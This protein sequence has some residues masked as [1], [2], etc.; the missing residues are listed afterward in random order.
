MSPSSSTEPARRFGLPQVAAA[1]VVVLIL[2]VV[3]KELSSL[4]QPLFFAIFFYYIG[5]P[6]SQLLIR[7][8]VPPILATLALVLLAVAILTLFGTIVGAHIEEFAAQFPTYRRKTVELFVRF[9][10]WLRAEYP[11]VGDRLPAD[12]VSAIPFQRLEGV[13]RAVVGSFFGF[14]TASLMVAFFLIF[15]SQEAS[16]LPKRLDAAYGDR[17]SKRILDV[18][19][20]INR[21]II[22]YVYVKG[23]A[24]LTVALLSFVALIAF[25][26]DYAVLWGVL[27]F[28]GN[29]IPYLGSAVAVALPLLIA[30]LSFSSL[31]PVFVLAAIL[32]AFQVLVSNYLEPRFAGETLNLSP[33]VVLTS[34]VF[35]GWLWGIV[36]LM[37]SIPIMV[38]LRIVFENLDST[39][40][41][42]I[43]MSYA[44][45]PPKSS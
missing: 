43:L 14:A 7:K 6:V 5:A 12:V 40:E 39:R 8:R 24:S 31:A 16:S 13:V 34:L 15:V 21:G 11:Y 37:L 25:R 1:S 33:L 20:R 10:G 45:K 42:A 29:F 27:F 44:T 9:T 19:R 2:V 41:A 28:L 23:L 4:L 18:G 32:I 17:R 30:L 26:V 38:S 22:H 35:W 3:L 36:G